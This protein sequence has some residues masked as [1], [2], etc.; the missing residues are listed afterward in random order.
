MLGSKLFDIPSY[1]VTYPDMDSLHDMKNFV[2]DI[3][4][5]MQ[6]RMVIF[7]IQVDDNFSYR[8]I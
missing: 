5:A 8:G 1:N 4:T 2:K 6:T 3:S 7:G